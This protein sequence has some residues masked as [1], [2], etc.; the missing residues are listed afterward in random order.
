MSDIQGFNHVSI[1]F[2]DLDSDPTGNTIVSI[3]DGYCECVNSNGSPSFGGGTLVGR[4]YYW[5]SL[6][7]RQADVPCANPVQVSDQS[8]YQITTPYVHNEDDFNAFAAVL[9]A[10]FP[11][12]TPTDPYP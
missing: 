6:L 2:V 12:A 1:S 8:F 4:V 10:K 3:P 7:D 9:A 5:N 11:S